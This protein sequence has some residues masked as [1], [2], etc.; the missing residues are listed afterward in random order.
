MNGK[1]D[2]I[3]SGIDII[4]PFRDKKKLLKNENTNWRLANHLC[5]TSLKRYFAG[6][7][8]SPSS[9]NLEY[10]YK[11]ENIEVCRIFLKYWFLTTWRPFA[12]YASIL[13]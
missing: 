8:V 12:N 6:E 9:V 4:Y 7:L 11:L 10:H 3:L 13:E 5:T 1:S 2:S